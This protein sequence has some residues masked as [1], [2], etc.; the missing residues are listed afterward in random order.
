M[1]QNKSILKT[2]IILII[3]L[4]LISLVLFS[5]NYNFN[6]I[7]FK[8]STT[9]QETDIFS[10]NN[11]PQKTDSFNLISQELIKIDKR[12]GSHF[13]FDTNQFID[14]TKISD[15]I[16][17]TSSK[18]SYNLK[19]TGPD[20]TFNHNQEQPNQYI[21]YNSIDSKEGISCWNNI[22][23]PIFPNPECLTLLNSHQTTKTS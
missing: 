10:L 4:I 22:L 9:K 5:I 19:F 16:N 1:P 20:V 12:T 13:C 21:C 15:L 6:L 7:N 14:G 17:Y 11:N 3:I 2:I 23:N 18:Y 8:N